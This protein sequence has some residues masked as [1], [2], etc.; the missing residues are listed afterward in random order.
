[1]S[2]VTVIASQSV[3]WLVTAL[4]LVLL[5]EPMLGF[6]GTSHTPFT[7]TLAQIFGS[8]LTGLALVSW[9]TRDTADPRKQNALLLSYFICN[10]LGFLVCLLGI[11]AGALRQAGWL[12]VGL[13][14]L[15]A[16]LFASLRFLKPGRAGK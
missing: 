13:Y 16:L 6:F 12:L 8:E 5:P 7:V 1:M 3:I 4:F 2:S 9:I 11:K 14:L 15:Y 10:S